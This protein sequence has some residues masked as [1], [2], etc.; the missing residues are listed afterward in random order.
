M[1]TQNVRIF[2]ELAD[3]SDSL[4]RWLDARDQLYEVV[5]KKNN[6]HL[7]VDN[8]SPRDSEITQLIVGREASVDEHTGRKVSAI[9]GCTKGFAL[10]VEQDDGYEGPIAMYSRLDKAEQ[11]AASAKVV[12]STQIEGVDTDGWDSLTGEHPEERTDE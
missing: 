9:P 12:V 8:E 7:F 10:F 5:D 6:T 3:P 2:R 4:T 1:A 11:A